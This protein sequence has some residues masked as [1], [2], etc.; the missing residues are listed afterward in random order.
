MAGVADPKG[1]RLL[2][3][4]L[5]F[6]KIVIV[7]IAAATCSLPAAGP[8]SIASAAGEAASTAPSGPRQAERRSERSNQR[9]AARRAR[10][11]ARRARAKR[12]AR[13]RAL[14]R[15]LGAAPPRPFAPSS[16]WNAPLPG[17][18][19]LDAKSPVY[20]DR[21]QRL[22]T[23]WEPYVNTTRYSTPVYTVPADQ[24]MVH[25]TLDNVQRDLQAAFDQVPIPQDAQP[26]AGTDGHMVVWQPSTDTMWEF[27]IARRLS[28]G[29]HARYGGRMTNVSTNPGHFTDRPRW[30]AT[31]TS[32]PLLGGLMCLE[33]LKTRR[34]D[35]A[36][37]IALPEIRAGAHS[38]PAQRS[39]GK[40]Y[41]PAA[42]PEGARFR[43]DPALD[44][45]EMKMSPV[46]RAMAV[47]AQRYGIVV[48]DGAG[49]VAFYAED[50][51]PTGTNPFAG[52]D[53]LFGGRYISET[54]RREFPWAHLKVLQ[55]SMTYS[56]Q[57]PL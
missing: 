28:D 23:Q 6:S 46:V 25:V 4:V 11:K 34:I 19:P 55:T 20:V 38:W 33:E 48:R 47:A 26:A 56:G 24:P 14:Q 54:L 43:I 17:N 36:L 44:L 49:S 50:P 8:V 35:H 52:R 12:R 16:F 5:M 18:A 41:D 3:P 57:G 21:L 30:G 40:A 32:L 10:A 29:W 2:P 22:L 7:L 45:S 13:A 9:S 39:D 31:A 1:K 37:A 27:W 51:T 53:G 15:G 42:I